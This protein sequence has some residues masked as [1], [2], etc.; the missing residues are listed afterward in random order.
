L[1]IREFYPKL[2]L[3]YSP[4]PTGDLSAMKK[5]NTWFDLVGNGIS[6]N[7]KSSAVHGTESASAPGNTVVLQIHFQ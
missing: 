2:T 3:Q 7:I 1:I 6:Q 5:K 4:L